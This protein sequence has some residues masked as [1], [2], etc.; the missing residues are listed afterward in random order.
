MRDLSL[1]FIWFWRGF[2]RGDWLWLWI[3]VL[4]AST[5]V[6]LVQQLATSVQASMLAKAAASLNADL[7]LRSSRPLEDI[8]D[9]FA[10]SSHNQ[11][12]LELKNQLNT[13]KTINLNTMAQV[14]KADNL[15]FQMVQLKG[16]E[17]NFPLRGEVLTANNQQIA[18]LFAET[19][20]EVFA[21]EQLAVLANLSIGDQIKLGNISLKI[22]DWLIKQDVF[23]SAAGQFAPQ[24]I[25]PLDLL[26]NMGLL[27][28][29]SRAT[30]E[31]SFSSKN[32]EQAAIDKLNNLL[33][34]L[35]NE[36]NLASWQII[37]ASAPNEDLAQNLDT[38][39][40][41]LDLTSLA[42]LII[43]GLAILIASSFYLSN[44]INSIAL[45]R[46]F[47]AKD[48]QI[49]RIFASQLTYLALF[50][51]G[52]G[53]LLGLGIF[54]LLTPLLTNY[55]EPL[56]VQNSWQNWLFALASGVL[57]LWAFAWPAFYRAINTL[58]L[59]VLR[60]QAANKIHWLKLYLP[61]LLLIPGLVALLVKPQI[62][63]FAL[64]G[65]AIVA[66]ALLVLAQLLLLIINK[67]QPQT[68]GWL[69]LALASINRQPDLVRL[70][71]I[72]LG[73]VM[74]VLISIS[75][76]QQDLLKSWQASMPTDTPNTFVISIQP[77][78]KDEFNQLLKAKSLDADLIPM[79]RGRLVAHND[80]NLVS[81]EHSGRA[82]RLLDREANI[83]ILDKPPAH[84]QVLQELTIIESK[85]TTRSGSVENQQENS[86]NNL[87]KVSV[88]A[89]IAKVFNIQL[90]DLLTFDFIGN[91]Q[92]YLVSSIRGLEWQSFRL[93][94]FFIL[95]PT[96]ENQRGISYISNF[97]SGLDGPATAQIKKQLNQELPGIIWLD[98]NQII[99]QIQE[100]MQQ[101]SI[102]I[103][104]L[105][106]LSL[107]ASFIVIFSATRASQMQ[108]I[109]SW[110]L[111]KTLGAT[112]NTLHKISLTEFGLIGVL[113][114]IISASLAQITSWLI[115]V[116]L[117]DL[118]A[119]FSWQ[120]WLLAIVASS[121]ILL[122]IGY[123][124]QRRALKLSVR[125]LSRI[126][127]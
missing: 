18:Q 41:F 27:G 59:R 29:G 88:E 1:A 76:V 11:A 78:Q 53:G 107:F 117:L 62:W 84:N 67:I 70:Q 112:S 80:K 105:Y 93:N 71:V 40:L 113:A 108:R 115:A 13:S 54:Y 89:G 3:A 16:V 121:G 110:I 94:F 58:P 33:Q 43:A 75:F 97:Y 14:G 15:E 25:L 126:R 38:A 26:E 24:I 19:K 85:A 81:S 17:A 101:A 68:R 46:S 5:S 48:Q 47:G 73:L 55:F 22:N 91:Q 9:I 31:I 60:E 39:W 21:S 103:S 102:A 69:R 92:T 63:V 72:A 74:F 104:L 51:S 57:A 20:S 124:T 116:F 32:G 98:V 10:N 119:S 4:I 100:I 44:W 114:G 83:A 61:L 56:I 109:Q 99:E 125:Q 12:W 111:L 52:L 66:L 37:S 87:P 7:V 6:S 77:E 127:A 2:K 30:F 82:K 8:D 42:S 65:L 90:G 45:M 34:G 79:Q 35:L 49:A 28:A 96:A 86:N 118:P 122:A 123:L 95:E 106:S 23:S 120:I 36:E 50:A 64:L